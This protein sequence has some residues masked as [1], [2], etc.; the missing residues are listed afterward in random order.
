MKANKLI[1][2]KSPY[3]LQHAYNP[4]EWYPWGEEAFNKA[5]EEDKPVFLS[6]GYSTCHWCHVMEK[7]SFEDNEVASSLNQ[8]FVSIKVDREERPD[9]DTVYMSVCQVLTGSGGWPLTIVMTPDKKPFFA[10]TYFPK[11]S[12][13]NRIGMLDLLSKINEMWTAKRDELVASSEKI[14]GALIQ[15]HQSHIGDEINP[16]AFD[17]AFLQFKERFDDE[18]GGFGTAPK[19]PS[20]HNLLFLLSYNKRTKNED[21]INMVEKTLLNMRLG[22]IYDHIGFGFHRYS[23]DKKWLLPHFEKMLYDQALLVQAYSNHYSITKNELSKRTVYEILQY[24]NG[25]LTAPEGA[26]YSAEDADSEGEEGKFYVWQK[27]EITNILQGD[28]DLICTLFNINDS[29]NFVDPFNNVPGKENIFY[30]KQPLEEI[31][32]TYDG[33]KCELIDKI[34]K[35]IKKLFDEREKRVHPLKDEKILTDWNGLMIAASARA[36]SV[37]REEKFLHAAVKSTRFIM[38]K[39]LSEDGRLLHRYKDGEAAITGTL[40]DYAFFI[41]GLLQ[42]YEADFNPEYLLLAL[43]LIDVQL[44]HFWDDEYGGF[45][46]TAD[47]AEELIIRPKDIYDGA[48]PSG[49]SVSFYNLIKL[50]KITGKPE[51]YDKIKLMSQSF[52]YQIENSPASHTFFLAAL[53]NLYNDTIEVIIAGKKEDVSTKAMLNL[54]GMNYNAGTTLVLLDEKREELEKIAP[55]LKSYISIDDKTT[56]YVCKN[57]TCELPVTSVEE[58]SQKIGIA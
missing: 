35:V 24:V 25:K 12:R 57:F 28:A 58:L 2:E 14:T 19:F 33:N 32:N 8:Y 37:F 50:Y 49:N 56:A 53:D 34:D 5:K 51:L 46:L 31:L 4:V 40:D 29:G 41:C 6:I 47:D 44:K 43:K 1:T 48:I 17:R 15:S 10:G 16:S 54:L 20:P 55:Y 38:E 45:F 21:A 23:T 36:Y 7:E 42:L 3:L 27:D 39:L 11:T 22:G 52:Y 18:Y 13:Y 26:F 9:I 30:L